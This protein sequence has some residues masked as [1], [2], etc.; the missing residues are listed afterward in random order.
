MDE[1]ELPGPR[2]QRRYIAVSPSSQQFA[3]VACSRLLFALL[4]GPKFA[5]VPPQFILRPKEDAIQVDAR[6]EGS[7]EEAWL[8]EESLVPPC[9]PETCTLKS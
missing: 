5:S 3:I 1:E 9:S 7:R 4:H 2:Q 8:H 6:R